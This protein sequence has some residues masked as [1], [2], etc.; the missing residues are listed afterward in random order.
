M[1]M[2]DDLVAAY[3]DRLLKV[4]CKPTLREML[5]IMIEDGGSIVLNSKDRT[6]ALALAIQG[7]KQTIVDGSLKAFVPGR[8]GQKDVTK[9]SLEEKLAYY[10][11]AG[12]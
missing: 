2:I 9:M 4:R 12:R 10:K 1:L 5:T 8:M 6:V 11:K 7:L 3:R